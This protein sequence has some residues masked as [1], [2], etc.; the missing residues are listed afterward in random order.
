[1]EGFEEEGFIMNIYLSPLVAQCGF[2]IL[3]FDPHRAFLG[4]V[5]LP[6]FHTSIM[7]FRVGVSDSLC[8]VQV[9]EFREN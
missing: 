1:M 7:K 8:R 2:C 6:H 4:L 5:L 3:S 9:S